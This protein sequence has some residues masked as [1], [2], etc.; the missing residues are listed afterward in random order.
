MTDEE[1]EEQ[2]A[3]V[4]ASTADRSEAE[5]LQAVEQI[6]AQ[7]LESDAAAQFELASAYDFA[8]R[9][10]DAEPLYRSAL[11]A[12]LDADRRPR[13]VIQLASTIRNL[14]RPSESV[15]L[16]EHE[17]ASG[18]EERTAT[19]TAFLAL[20]LVDAGRPNEAVSRLLLALVPQIPEYSRAITFYAG[21]IVGT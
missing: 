6:V 13:A 20:A 1:F 9:E 8:D 2:I 10:A 17:L 5:V 14:G 15:E 4:W 12:R 18:D 3:E 19:L 11:A 16:L 21:E 7:R